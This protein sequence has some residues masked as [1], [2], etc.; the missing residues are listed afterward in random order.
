M[1]IAFHTP[2]NRYG[3]GAPSG[4]R[5]MARQLV[6]LLEDLVHAVEIVP[7][8]RSFM[9]EPDPV[10]LAAHKKAA[11]DVIAALTERWQAPKARPDLFFTY[12]CHYRAPDLIGPALVEHFALPYLIAEASDAQKRFTGPWAEAAALAR[13]AILRADLH[14]CMTERDREGL[15]RLVPEPERLVD[16]PPFLLGVEDVPEHSV[17]PRE[18]NEPV[19]LIAVA[20]MRQGNKAA[21]YLFL[22]RTLA[23]IADLPWTL[24]LIGDGPERS[25]IEAAFAGFPPG[26]I[27]FL[28]RRERAEILAELATHDLFVWPGLNEAYG[29]VYLEAQAA[30]LAVAALD[31]G[32]VPAVVARDRTALLAPHG[33][34]AALA[35]TIARLVKDSGLRARMGGAAQLFARQERNGDSARK[36][37]AGAL[38]AAIARHGRRA[39]E[40]VL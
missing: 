27:R 25:V 29:V 14:L 2:L 24:T 19:R 40:T 18:G 32:G 15:S 9:R 6:T 13:E 38:D 10:L 28:G 22:A 3:D 35:A 5:L 20:M 21:C 4:D 39:P 36:I 8:E 26:R 34:E 30:G 31:S 37:L 16:L 7:A 33:D 11:Q 17:A 1:K 12:H 23:H